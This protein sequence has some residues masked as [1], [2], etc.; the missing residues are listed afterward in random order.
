MMKNVLLLTVIALLFAGC[1]PKPIVKPTTPTPPPAPET[2]K[3]PSQ[4]SGTGEEKKE[5]PSTRYVDWTAIQQL[6]VVAFDF[7]KADLGQDA[8]TALKANA[9]YLKL[10]SNLSILVEGHC[11]ERGTENYNLAL[12]QK[13]AS[14]VREYY[15]QLGIPLARIATISY[16]AEKPVDSAH[17]ESAWAKNRRA[18]TKVRSSK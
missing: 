3:T 4:P 16:G 7:D 1:T 12:G 14:A 2:S 5:E 11:D 10:N 18:E 13:R 9:E 17:N 15:G 8:R 6:K